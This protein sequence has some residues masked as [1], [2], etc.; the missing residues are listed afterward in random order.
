VQ[1]SPPPPPPPPLCAVDGAY[2]FTGA[3]ASYL[4]A[5]SR[6]GIVGGGL[7]FTLC[8]WPWV[9]RTQIGSYWG[10]VIDFGN[11]HAA[12]LNTV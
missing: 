4:T 6:T 5:T 1:P 2:T 7:G 9:Y 8:A 12:N 11:G 10:R 3:A